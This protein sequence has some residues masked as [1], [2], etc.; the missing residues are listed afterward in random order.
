M[1]IPVIWFGLNPAEPIRGCYFDQGLLEALLA[2]ELWRPPAW[3]EFTHHEIRDPRA[4]DAFD[5][6]VVVIRGDHHL[7][8]IPELNEALNRLDWVLLI[9]TGDEQARF[10]WRDIKHPRLTVWLQTP[11]RGLHD[12]I[13]QA[14]PSG[15]PPGTR[16]ALAE[17]SEKPLDWAYLGQVTNPMRRAWANALS[18]VPNGRLL[19][20][21][22]FT[23][24]LPRG[25]YL[26]TL[27]HAKL[28]PAPGGVL[29]PDTFRIY[30]SLEAGCLPIVGPDPGIGEADDYFGAVFGD[31]PLPVCS[32]PATLPVLMARLLEDWPA[33][34]IRAGCWWMNWKRDLAYKLRD[35]I[36]DL[37][38]IKVVGSHD[39]TAVVTCSP[40]PGHPSTSILDETLASIRERLPHAEI[41]CAF[42]GVHPTW[43]Y[44]A[45]AYD[46]HQRRVLR[47]STWNLLPIRAEEHLHQANLTRL[48]LEKVT[49]PL[50]LFVEHD[51]PLLG[52][53]DFETLARPVA[54]GWLDVLRFYPEV[55]IPDEHRYLHTGPVE[56]IGGVPVQRTFQWSQRPHLARTDWYRSILERHFGP[57]AR[58]FI[59]DAL[60]GSVEHSMHHGTWDQWRVAIYHPDGD[61]KRSGHTDGRAQHV[62][63][64][65]TFAYSGPVP[66]GSPFPGTQA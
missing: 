24:G 37:A 52:D 36:H 39:I 56:P 17:P 4:L 30:E 8:L 61:I 18:A 35:T 23:Q 40:I 28:A 5:G 43:A 54:D 22:G 55:A 51:T 11:R 13:G 57:E 33:N 38:S 3:P 29:T 21:P 27:S 31:H 6:G 1:T 45:D 49:T 41:I 14:L 44:H 50:I 15:F 59:E 34:A 7:D 19:E 53:L 64:P 2:G 20:T 12:G 47:G 42:D 16:Q 26:E 46:E 65:Q 10:R 32:E 48:A 58:C 62:K 25:E 9:Q 60:Y 63:I 66:P